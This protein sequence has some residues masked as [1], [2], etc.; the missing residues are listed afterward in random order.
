MYPPWIVND[1]GTIGFTQFTLWML[2]I[3]ALVLIVVLTAGKRL[4][5]V[6]NN[7]FVNMVE[8]GINTCDS[9]D[10]DRTRG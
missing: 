2:I 10:A 8:Y 4:T 1:G 6:P 9:W 3:F 5:L 7:K